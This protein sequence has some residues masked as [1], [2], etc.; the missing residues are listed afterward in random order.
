MQ[1]NAELKH[2]GTVSAQDAKAN[3]PEAAK[4]TRQSDSKQ[5][6][7]EIYAYVAIRDSLLVEAEEMLTGAKLDS[8][9]IANEFV[10]TCLKLARAPYQSQHLP[11]VDAARERKRCEVVT[12]RIAKLRSHIVP[13]P[14]AYGLAA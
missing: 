6:F 8:V 3:P 7:E 2:P 11:E 1:A 14:F 9:A 12:R 10:E 4:S 5:A 13:R